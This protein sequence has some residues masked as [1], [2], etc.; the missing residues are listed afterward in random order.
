MEHVVDMLLE[1]MSWVG[2]GTG[3]LVSIAAVILHLADG[4]WVPIRAYV[5]RDVDTDSDTDSDETVARWFDDTGKVGRVVLRPEH[6]ERVD[7]DMIDIYCRRGSLS[8]YRVTPGWP[9]ARATGLFG[10]GLLALGIVAVAVSFILLFVR[11]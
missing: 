4:H 1:I 10:A 5:D 3:I 7:G 8:R 6:I 9:L 2:I 11:G